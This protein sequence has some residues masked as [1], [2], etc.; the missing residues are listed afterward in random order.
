[1][2]DDATSVG[3]IKGTLDLD[4]GPWDRAIA[5]VKGDVAEIKGLD[6][7]VKLTAS[8]TEAERQIAIVD[9]AADRL[10]AKSVTVRVKAD[11]SG[12]DAVAAAE[13]KVAAAIQ[14]SDTA[15]ARA[16]IS[17][18]RLAELREKGSVSASQM[19]AAE[20]ALSV[21]IQKSETAA[22][23][24]AAAEEA[25]AAAQAEQAATAAASAGAEAESAASMDADS[26]ST[27]ANTAAHD[28][29]SES[30][31]SSIAQNKLMVAG[32][33]A[34]VAAA[35][36]LSGTL[37]ALGG[38]FAAEG[39][40]GAAAILG[41]KN[42]MEAGT[43]TGQQYSSGLQSLKGDL[44]QLGS[45]AAD[46]MLAS[47]ES[48][49]SKVNAAMPTLNGYVSEFAGDLGQ[50]GST[51]LD[52][53]LDALPIIDP[54]LEDG[55]AFIQRLADGVEDF[56]AGGG[57]KQFVQYAQSELPIVEDAIMS[58]GR[59]GVDILQDLAPAGQL[60]LQL[61]TLT[62]DLVD[63]M[64]ELNTAKLLEGAQGVQ[65]YSDKLKTASTTGDVFYD[66]VMSGASV[67]G[68]IANVTKLWENNLN[69]TTAA[70]EHATA[71][72][73][74]QA[75][76]MTALGAKYDMTGEAYKTAA[77]AASKQ[78]AQTKA[79]TQA[80]QLEND[81]AGLLTASLDLMNGKTLGQAE[82]QTAFA[83]ANNSLTESLKT[84]G[85]AIEGNS[86]KAVANQQ[87]VQQS[88]SA[89][90]ALAEATAKST[91]STAAGT[92]SLEDSKAQLEAQ[93]PALKGY[94]DRILQ[95][96]KTAPTKAELDKSTADAALQ[97]YNGALNSVPRT[98]ATT[99][100]ANTAAANAAIRT[101]INNI[102]NIPGYKA[103]V[104]DQQIK[105]SGAD[106]G[107][108]G[109][110]YNSHGGEIAQHF[111]SGGTSG[112]VLGSVG[113]ATSDSL[114]TH[115]SI[116][117]E[118]TQAYAASYPGVRPL[119]KAVN[120]DPAGTMRALSQP[121]QQAAPVS[122]YVTNKAGVSLDDL[123][124]IHIERAGQKQR[125]ALSAGRQNGTF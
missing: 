25:L 32:I 77:D 119:L 123:I 58:I 82:A 91:G 79:A 97:S 45:T 48:S 65:T 80:M 84:N 100:S 8:I 18:L 116:G 7:D 56:A 108:V 103:V 60:L 50:T 95:I 57:L 94:I 110:A 104:I 62:G 88:V 1:M 55:A 20:L 109:A 29:N 125:V 36:P 34:L 19:A 78:V 39:A 54:L 59:A 83:G 46:S 99:A 92:K 102:A 68:T 70:Q 53:L 63:G 124:E 42:D 49:V 38:A 28:S 61:V 98:V 5:Q 117:E 17:E 24:A 26:A 2:A 27:V 106:R 86:A 112:T 75:D 72:A 66:S 87:A 96:P 9:A 67:V 89:A 85:T 69:G 51:L 122:V 43:A 31:F 101:L 105:Q 44:D 73:R 107:A 15:T 81:A 40:A 13:A 47:F 93:Y 113:S 121:S 10:D 71:Q 120:A 16:Q 4:L 30:I 52:A 14:V 35:G 115:L 21:A 111:A 22:L 76:A 41:I 11:A 118:V 74:V 23:K 64:N 6:A 114:L 33:V 12:T 37:V 3:G 90:Q